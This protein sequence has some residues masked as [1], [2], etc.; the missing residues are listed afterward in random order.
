MSDRDE[1]GSELPLAALD[2]AQP[3]ER[4]D[5]SELADPVESPEPQLFTSFPPPFIVKKSSFHPGEP[6]PSLLPKFGLPNEA[7]FTDLT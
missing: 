2:V 1:A 7:Q 3:P 4:F 6:L 5:S